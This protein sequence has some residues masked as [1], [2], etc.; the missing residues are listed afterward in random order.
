M[1]KSWQSVKFVPRS[2]ALPRSNSICDLTQKQTLTK[3]AARR[4]RE[5]AEI[6]IEP[7][8]ERL[9]LLTSLA[10]GRKNLLESVYDAL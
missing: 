8:I 7:S 2:E 3:A 4:L 5:E 9:L 6:E 1:K 10:T